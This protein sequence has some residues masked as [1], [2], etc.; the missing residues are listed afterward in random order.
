MPL[1]S[2][3]GLSTLLRDKPADVV[4]RLAGDA[5]G[6]PLRVQLAMEDNESFD[7]TTTREESGQ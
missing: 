5:V 3:F 6:I 4:R 7:D 2:I 1:I